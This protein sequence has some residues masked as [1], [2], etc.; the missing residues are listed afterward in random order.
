VFFLIR[1][2][3][4]LADFLGNLGELSFKT[5]GL[6]ASAKRQRVEAAA[7]LGAAI[8]TRAPA[9][10]AS[11]TATDPRDVVEAL[12]TTRS[13]R[14]LQGRRILWVDDRPENNRFERQ[15]LEALGLRIDLSTSTEDA[16][17]KTR[18]RSYDL[19]ISDMGR[20]P[21]A[22]AGYTLLDKL[23]TAGDKTPF[24]IYAGSRAPE[25]VE[26]GRRHGAT[27]TTNMPQ[28]LITMATKALA[29]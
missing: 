18:Q 2:R 14:R 27:G 8:A 21:D 4:G 7:A 24:I 26:E 6:E 9:D 29:E 10:G 22:R 17:Q 11:A 13:Q 5:P 23:R 15:A 16:L 3:H 25:H 12:P 20:P 28:E 1:F 19:I